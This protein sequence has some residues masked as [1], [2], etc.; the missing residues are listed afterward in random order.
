[1]AEKW[2]PFN[3]STPALSLNDAGLGQVVISMFRRMWESAF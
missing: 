3:P 1:M 2:S